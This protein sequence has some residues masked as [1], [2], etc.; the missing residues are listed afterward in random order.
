MY[1]IIL[2]LLCVC[3][4]GAADRGYEEM[5]AFAQYLRTHVQNGG[6]LATL[7]QEEFNRL[8][9]YIADRHDQ[10]SVLAAQL[11]ENAKKNR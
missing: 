8:I 9:A 5:L 10:F 7:S 2:A 3:S 1:F 11:V 4:V 6:E